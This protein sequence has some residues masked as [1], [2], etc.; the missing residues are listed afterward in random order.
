VTMQPRLPTIVGPVRWP[1]S[2]RSPEFAIAT[3][4]RPFWIVEMATDR[5][6][7]GGAEQAR[8]EDNY[9]FGSDRPGVIGVG[10]AWTV[11]PETWVRFRRSPSVVYRVF[12]FARVTWSED[13]AVSVGD[14]ELADLPVLTISGQHADR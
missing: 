4:G 5:A 13:W 2:G 10:P 12:A 6:L 3:H 8:T 7:V 11:P 14:G 1:A 9:F